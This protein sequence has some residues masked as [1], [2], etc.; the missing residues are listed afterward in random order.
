MKAITVA[1]IAFFFIRLLMGEVPLF[2]GWLWLDVAAAV[3]LITVLAVH[4]NAVHGVFKRR[5]AEKTATPRF[6]GKPAVQL[7]SDEDVNLQRH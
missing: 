3:G 5:K 2:D 1:L 6:S 4:T 7:I